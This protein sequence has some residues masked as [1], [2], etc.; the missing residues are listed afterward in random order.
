MQHIL[1]AR[2]VHPVARPRISG[3]AQAALTPVALC[4]QGRVRAKCS[5]TERRKL[6]PEYARRVG[7]GRAQSGG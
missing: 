6:S 1:G 3:H 4:Q 7:S 5:K 2:A